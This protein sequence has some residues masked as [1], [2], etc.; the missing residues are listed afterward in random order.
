V[1]LK[2][3]ITTLYEAPI[4]EPL[5]AAISLSPDWKMEAFSGSAVA[6]RRARACWVRAESGEAETAEI[7]RDHDEI[8]FC[9]SME[10]LVEAIAVA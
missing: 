10:F 5:E 9:A 6:P 1:L 2:S 7:P 4:A 3:A 8:T